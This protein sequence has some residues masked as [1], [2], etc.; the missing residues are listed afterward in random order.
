MNGWM[1]EWMNE[2]MTTLWYLTPRS[3]TIIKCELGTLPSGQVENRE[4]ANTKRSIWTFRSSVRI[5]S[6]RIPHKKNPRNRVNGQLV[7][8]RFGEAV[9]HQNVENFWKLLSLKMG[10]CAFWHLKL[11]EKNAFYIMHFCCGNYTF[12]HKNELRNQRR[13]SH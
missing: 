13:P 1:N 8:V 6:R 11:N 2:W 7:R 4:I 10:S 5:V 9:R 12:W 3:S